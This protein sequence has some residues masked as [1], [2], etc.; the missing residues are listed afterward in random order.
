MTTHVSTGNIVFEG[1]SN[2]ET[3]GIL[4]HQPCAL[5][6]AVNEQIFYVALK[7]TNIVKMEIISPWPENV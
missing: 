7:T 2:I 6:I 5:R 3:G 4:I 1:C